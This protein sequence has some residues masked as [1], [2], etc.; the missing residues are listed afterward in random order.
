MAKRIRLEAPAAADLAEFEAGFAA[1]PTTDRMGLTASMAPIAQIAGDIAR[2]G[3]PLDL[4]KRVSIGNSP[5]RRFRL[6]A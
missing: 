2:S 6:S 1:Q 5:G 3:E 4:A